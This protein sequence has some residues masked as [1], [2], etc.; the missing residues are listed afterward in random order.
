MQIKEILFETVCEHTVS[1]SDP[2]WKSQTEQYK[3]LRARPHTSF[4]N[5]LIYEW[6]KWSSMDRKGKWQ[7]GRPCITYQSTA[8]EQNH[9]DDEGF[10]PVV[11][12]YLVAGFPQ[13]P[14]EFAFA[15]FYAY[16]TTLELSYTV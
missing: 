10:K 7:G 3:P 13:V 11:L 2:I 16:L 5:I 1:E 14:P 8:A 6:V 12:Y 15:F 9:E 4:L